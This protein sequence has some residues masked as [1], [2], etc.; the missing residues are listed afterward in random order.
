[1]GSTP[2][3]KQEHSESVNRFIDTFSKLYGRKP[4][5]EDAVGDFA[6]QA[7]RDVQMCI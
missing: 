6:P 3:E 2:V 1:M 7:A 5:P 4:Q